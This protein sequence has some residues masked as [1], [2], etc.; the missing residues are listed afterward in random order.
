[1]IF[2]L[3]SLWFTAGWKTRG[4]VLHSILDSHTQRSVSGRC[5]DCHTRAGLACPPPTHT[6]AETSW[7]PF[8]LSHYYSKDDPFPFKKTSS[9]WNALGGTSLTSREWERAG[10]QIQCVCVY[11][12][13][14]LWTCRE[15][16]GWWENQ[17]WSLQSHFSSPF[18]VYYVTPD[19]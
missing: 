5:A 3:E 18:I 1:M 19:C 16:T 4:G 7:S 6:P 11:R 17:T 9:T 15:K 14:G 12:K 2:L 8:F 13:K 10:G